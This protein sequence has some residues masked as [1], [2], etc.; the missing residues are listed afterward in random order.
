LDTDDIDDIAFVS[1]LVFV[2]AVA[3]IFIIVLWGYAIVFL[4]T[5]FSIQPSQG[6]PC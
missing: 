3:F 1:L 5:S 6:I 4:K 2:L